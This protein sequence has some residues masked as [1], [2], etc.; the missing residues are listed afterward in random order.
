[1]KKM[2]FKRRLCLLKN[3]TLLELLIVVA[4][5][6]ILVSILLPSLSRAREKTKFAVC[7][8]QKGQNHRM[9]MTALVDN[10]QKLP[11]FSYSLGWNQYHAGHT[12]NYK[13]DDWMGAASKSGRIVNPVAAYY[14]GEGEDEFYWGNPMHSN[15]THSIQNIMRCPSIEKGNSSQANTATFGSNGTFDYSFP[16][17]FSGHYVTKFEASVT[18]RPQVRVKKSYGT[19]TVDGGEMEMPTPLIIEEDPRMNMGFG[20]FYKETAWGNGDTVGEWHDF[21]KKGSYLGL[22]G[23]VVILRTNNLIPVSM[24]R[25]S[26]NWMHMGGEMRLMNNYNSLFTPIN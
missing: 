9:I 24:F 19:I 13:E 17:S 7:T 18:W 23:S 1:M 10:N 25:S 6:A 21:G 22:D 16:Q 3:F 5:I 20:Q 15:K 8:S 2:I 26:N 12:P 11:Q 4:I 14:F